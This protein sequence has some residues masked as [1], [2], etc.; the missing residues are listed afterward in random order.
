MNNKGHWCKDKFHLYWLDENK[1]IMVIRY[2]KTY[3]WH[4]YYAMME[5]AA[6][7]VDGITHPIV[8]INDFFDDIDIPTESAAPHYTNMRRMFTT[9]TMVLILRTAQQVIQVQ[10]YSNM[11]GFEENENLFTASSFDE[12]VIIAE[13]AS[14]R[15]LNQHAVVGDADAS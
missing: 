14:K 11:V 3:D 6:D 7:M 8:Y 12:A 13:R 5:V 15:L 9:P 2:T 10:T 1:H 4:D